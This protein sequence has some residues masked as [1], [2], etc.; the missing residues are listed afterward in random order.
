[1]KKYSSSVAK[2]NEVD[3]AASKWLILAYKQIEIKD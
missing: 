3:D 1:V 2:A